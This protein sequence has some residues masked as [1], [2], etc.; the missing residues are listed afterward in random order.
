[1]R[2]CLV[3]D[4][5]VSD[6]EPLTLTRPVF[7]LRLGA[8]TLGTKLARAFRIAP[9]PTRRGALIRPHLAALCRLR[10]PGLAVNDRT[11]LARAPLLVANARWVPPAELLPPDPDPPWVGT[12]DGRP[13]C[14]A[15]GPDRAAALEWGG[16]DAWFDAVA[17][18]A[19]VVDLGGEWIAHPRDL[20]AKNA[21]HLARDAA[22]A[23]GA[24]LS[25]R[26]RARA[27]VV[28]PADRLVIHATARIDPYTVFDTT[29]GPITLAAGVVVQPFTRVEGP[30]SIGRDTQLF[31]A[32]LRGGVTLGPG[33]R[34]GGE[35]E[36]GLDGGREAVGAVLP[37][38]PSRFPKRVLQPVAQ[39]LPALREADGA[40]LPVGVG[41]HEVVDQVL[42]RV[43]GDGDAQ[44]GHVREVR[45]TEPPRLVV[46]CEEH[47][48]GRPFEGPP[49]FERHLRAVSSSIPA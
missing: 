31:R 47:L 22:P 25:R 20:V 24:G 19:A 6:L 10:D 34:I 49:P 9:A 35:V 21:D 37:G 29:R 41:Q 26:H 27:A 36:V 48:L 23:G 5:A 42:E 28:G 7:D 32:H 46:L 18:R 12:R 15:V 43:A 1:M 38:D 2:L 39:A 17:S 33:C 30:C 13:A 14:A 45:G 16:I 11:W 40:G 44:F 4:Q 3:E 8:Q